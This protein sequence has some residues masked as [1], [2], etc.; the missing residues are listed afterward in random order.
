M[1]RQVFHYDCYLHPDHAPLRIS[2]LKDTLHNIRGTLITLI[3]R[4]GHHNDG[5]R[6]V[7]AVKSEGSVEG[8]LSPLH[9]FSA[10][11][12][13][14]TSFPVLFGI[15]TTTLDG[16]PELAEYLHVDYHGWPLDI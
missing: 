2:I 1:V 15:K 14:T 9:D 8:S 10:L 4:Y 5:E 13:L 7:I 6:N 12:S 16:T 3:V 11:T